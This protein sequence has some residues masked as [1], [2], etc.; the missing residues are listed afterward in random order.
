MNEVTDKKDGEARE[1]E[2]PSASAENEEVP[3]P[4]NTNNHD[5]SAFHEGVIEITEQAEIPVISKEPRVVEEIFIHKDVEEHNEKVTDLVRKKEVNIE[6]TGENN[7][8][9]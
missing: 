7:E 4:E 5:F 2:T 3:S 9:D 8:G 6:R 1:E